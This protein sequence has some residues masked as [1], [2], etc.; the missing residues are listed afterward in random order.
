MYDRNG[1]IVHEGEIVTIV[2]RPDIFLKE[3]WAVFSLVGTNFIL[4]NAVTNEIV[5]VEKDNVQRTY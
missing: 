4:K 3:S 1:K 5:F 2:N